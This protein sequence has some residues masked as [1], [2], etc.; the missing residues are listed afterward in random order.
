MPFLRQRDARA[1]HP[2][3]SGWPRSPS[4]TSTS[5]ACRRSTQ[6]CRDL[7]AAIAPTS[8]RT[9]STC[10]CTGAT[11]TGTRCSPTPWR[12][13]AT[14]GSTS[15][16]GFVTSAV[17]RLL[18]LPAVPGRHRRGPGARSG[19]DAP[20][21][22]KLRHFHDH[23]GFVEPH[24][25]AVRAA[26]ATLD[27]ARRGQHAAGL[28]RPLDP[29]PRWTPP[30]GPDGRPVHARSC[31]ETAALV[32][33][34]AA[35]DLEWDLVWQSRS[36]PPQVPWLEP[37][38]NDHLARAGRER[39]SPSVV[40]SPIGFVSD[41]LEVLWDLD[42]EARDDRRAARARLR[43]GRHAGHRPAVRDDGPGAGR[44]S[45]SPAHVTSS[46]G[47]VRS[48]PGTSARPTAACHRPAYRTE[49]FLREHVRVRE[50]KPIESWLTDMDG[51]LVHEGEPVPG[52]PEFVNR[53]RA[54]GKPFLI[55]TNNSIY[56]ARDLQARLR[57]IGLRRARVG[58]LDLG[59]GHRPVPGRPAPG[60][61][62]VRHRRGRPDHRDARGRLHPDRLRPGLRG[63][64]R[65]PHL[66]LRGDHH[67][68]S[69]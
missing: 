31:S 33:A 21:I 50:R 44:R 18:V 2:R 3:A 12:R 5:A 60:R 41:H 14:T 55:L 29:D 16:L 45:A 1:R 13:C 52:A 9:A 65:D 34:A 37:D 10:R 47:S 40:V 22:D 35:P 38:I 62:R 36:G 64:G 15:A 61:H 53:L 57:R 27:P 32:A 56:T 30:P 25:D 63:A 46:R 69:G 26:L 42:N 28:H 11:A 24:A 19:P 39:A 8:P 20:V 4:T 48:R 67:R 6:Q 49:T 7:L 58:D 51:V 23:P 43:P 54:S 59:P 66:Q 17:R 68:R